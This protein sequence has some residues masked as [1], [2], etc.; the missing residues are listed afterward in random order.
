MVDLRNS[1]GVWRLHIAERIPNMI[2]LYFICI[3]IMKAPHFFY[4]RVEYSSQSLIFIMRFSSLIIGSTAWLVA[5]VAAQGISKIPAAQWATGGNPTN[6]DM[7]YYAPPNLPPNS[8][9]V[10]AVRRYRIHL[11]YQSMLKPLTDPLLPWIR[12]HV[13]Q[14]YELHPCGQSI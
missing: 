4:R 10:V 7:F 8:P 2:E 9:V 14:L 11:A 1:L 13:F 5:S 12:H 3:K 6:L